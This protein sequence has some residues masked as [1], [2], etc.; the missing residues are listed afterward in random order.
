MLPFF[1]AYT[2]ADLRISADVVR[3]LP[4]YLVLK[5]SGNHVYYERKLQ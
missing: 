1:Y 3:L 4:L 5:H 2:N